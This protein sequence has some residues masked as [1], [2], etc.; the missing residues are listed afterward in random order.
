LVLGL[1]AGCEG[2]R[3]EFLAC[4]LDP[5]VLQTDVCRVAAGSDSSAQKSCVVTDHPQCPDDV[6][7]S[8][9]GSDAFCTYGCTKDA[10]CPAGAGCF[11]YSTRVVDGAP[12]EQRY[13]IQDSANPCT[14]SADCPSDMTCAAGACRMK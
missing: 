13:C 2:G 1:L 14:T 11:L 7:M 12:K 5:F 4:P 9:E 3:E 8:W 6:C 10:D